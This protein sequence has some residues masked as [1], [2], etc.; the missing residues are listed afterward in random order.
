MGFWCS[1]MLGSDEK[2]RAGKQLTVGSCKI[3]SRLRVRRHWSQSAYS[4]TGCWRL[5]LKSLIHWPRFL[6]I[7]PVRSDRPLTS[8]S[9][10]D[11]L[12]LRDLIKAASAFQ[13]AWRRSVQGNIV[14]VVREEASWISHWRC[15]LPDDIVVSCAL[16]CTLL[17]GWAEKATSR[18]TMLDDVTI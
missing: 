9:P 3:G 5:W 17:A 7:E 12:L 2:E 1:P 13:W 14:E 11:I 8:F 18:A 4:T 10:L 15:G 16:L 6:V